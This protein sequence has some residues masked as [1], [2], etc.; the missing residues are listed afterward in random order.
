[1]ALLSRGARLQHW[2][3]RSASRCDDDAPV[4]ARSEIVDTSAVLGVL[5]AL[6]VAAP[7]SKTLLSTAFADLVAA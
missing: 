3:L 1:M 2:Y 5:H 6:S 4:W 7:H